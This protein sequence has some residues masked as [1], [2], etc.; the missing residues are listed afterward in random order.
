MAKANA[1]VKANTVVK[2]VAKAEEEKKINARTLKFLPAQKLMR[3][4]VPP[5]QSLAFDVSL[6]SSLS[7]PLGLSPALRA[8]FFL[9][10]FSLCFV[11]VSLTQRVR[12]FVC[13]FSECLLYTLPFYR[14]LCVYVCACVCIKCRQRRPVVVVF[15]WC[16]LLQLPS[17]SLPL[18]LPFC[19]LSSV[20]YF[21]RCLFPMCLGHM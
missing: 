12:S 6:S 13:L 16:V 15:A 11:S 19:C 1:L 17:P 21:I 9:C 20:D 5:P 4:S 10:T 2:T 14:P 3:V 18:L 7:L 8:L